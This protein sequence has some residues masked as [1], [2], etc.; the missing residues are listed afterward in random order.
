ML[1]RE[2][3]YTGPVSWTGTMF[4]YYMPH[5]L[6]PLYDGTLGKEAMRFLLLLPEEKGARKKIFPGVFPK[7]DFMRLIRSSIISIR[8]T[9]CRSLA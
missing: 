3:R 5:L 2:G 8:R 9:A 7:A 4:E 1:A 6:L